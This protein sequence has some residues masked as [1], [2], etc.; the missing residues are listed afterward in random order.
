MIS[1]TA[2][3]MAASMEQRLKQPRHAFKPHTTPPALVGA[4]AN[5]ARLVA[6]SSTT[7]L[8]TEQVVRAPDTK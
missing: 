1:N 6:P 5:D 4:M 7:L 3:T 8:Q 2:L